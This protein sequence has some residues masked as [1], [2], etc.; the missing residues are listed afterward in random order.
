LYKDDSSFICRPIVS[1][2]LSTKLDLFPAT[3]KDVDEKR[4]PFR[5]MGVDG[6]EWE[7]LFVV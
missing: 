7:S 1:V 6:A 4:L 5:E 3:A 2:L